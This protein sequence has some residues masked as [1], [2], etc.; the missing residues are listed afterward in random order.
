MLCKRAIPAIGFSS[1][2][3]ISAM[4]DQQ[5]AETRPVGLGNYFGQIEFQL[6][7]V[8]VFGKPQPARE[9]DNVRITCDTGDSE[10]VAENAVGRFAGSQAP[11]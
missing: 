5:M 3:D 1:F 10:G 11:P 6:Y 7:R 2:T 8:A 9:P 4:M